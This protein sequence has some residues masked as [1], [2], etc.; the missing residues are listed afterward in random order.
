MPTSLIIG[1]GPAAAGVALA[2]AT[3]RDQ[4]ITVIDV[5]GGL[6]SDRQSTVNLLG[7]LPP[8]EWPAAQFDAIR[9]QPVRGST[10]SLPEKRTYGSDY[11]FRDF[12]QLQGL[13]AEVPTNQAVISGAYGGFSNAWGAQVMPFSAA[14][15]DQWPFN[16]S[17]LDGH[18]R[19]I[20]SHIPFA[21]EEDDLAELFPLMV[22]P[23]PLPPVS[24]RTSMIL[25]SYAQHRERLGALG[26]T[27]GHARLAFRAAKCIRCGLCMTGC[28]YSLIYSSAQTFD[29]LRRTNRIDYHGGLVAYRIGE[30]SHGPTVEARDRESGQHRQ[31]RADRVFVAC[32]GMG[33][34]RLVLG[35]LGDS[36]RE[37]TLGESVQFALP[38]LSRR[39]IPDPRSAPD[40]TL[41]QFNMIIAL[42]AQGLDVSQVHFYPYNPALL[43]ALPT[44]LRRRLGMPLSVHIL[45]HLTIGLGYLPSWASPRLR[46]RAKMADRNSL[47]DLHVSQDG[48]F[49]DT[50]PMLRQVLRQIRRAAPLLDLWP[51][52]PM[53]IVS[54]AAKSYHF[55]GSFPHHRAGR[56]TAT[57]TDR[58]GRLPQWQRIHLVDGSVFPSVPATTFTLTVMANAHRIAEESLELRDG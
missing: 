6:E 49:P 37:V 11:P 32:G 3:R 46:V 30:D 8:E 7:S 17:E 43:D 33:T 47:P 23:T 28:P 12:G 48:G 40:F 29:E 54:A 14:T 50:P 36:D 31:F 27:L 25:G 1:S 35:S 16:R 41:N 34:T 44:I 13:V 22:P 20:L 51:V 52:T 21:G 10:S 38:A 19:A 53:L 26:V 4:R 2:L 57:T 9:R 56:G 5:G 15:F 18:Y 58:L 24:P 55:G 45:R 39:S 42:D